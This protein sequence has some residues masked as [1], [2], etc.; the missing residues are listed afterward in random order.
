MLILCYSRRLGFALKIQL[1]IFYATYRKDRTDEFHAH[2]GGLITL[3]RD[4]ID[5]YH[6]EHEIALVPTDLATE[7]L[8]V[9][10]YF[11]D[12]NFFVSNVYCPPYCLETMPRRNSG[13][14]QTIHW[15]KL[16]LLDQT[17]L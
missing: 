4:N 14:L 5:I 12:R 9:Q 8:R 2:G 16:Y 1:H 17:I 13:S 11:Q 15:V 3:V 6:R 10:I 7:I